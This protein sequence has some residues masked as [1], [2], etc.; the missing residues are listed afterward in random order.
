MR[1]IIQAQSN[2][3]NL[4]YVKESFVLFIDIVSRMFCDTICNCRSQP[5]LNPW[6]LW[7]KCSAKYLMSAWR[8][9]WR[10]LPSNWPM[11]SSSTCHPCQVEL[12][13]PRSASSTIPVFPIWLILTELSANNFF[14]QNQVRITISIHFHCCKK[15][16]VRYIWLLVCMC[17]FNL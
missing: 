15:L 6:W 9:P 10:W 8:R 14:M 5:V 1:L 16:T 2:H 17:L 7:A 3:R 12:C 13:I 4:W 11:A